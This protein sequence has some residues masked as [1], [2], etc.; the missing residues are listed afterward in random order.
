MLLA[1]DRIALAIDHARL[2]E[3]ERAAR[4]DAEA[5]NR[6]K[7]QFLATLSHELR[8]PLTSML[9]WLRM[10]RSGRLDA[11]MA[12]RALETLERSTRTQAQLINDLLDVSRIVSGKLTLDLG[13]VDADEV[14]A[15]A[16][17]AARPL[18]EAKSITVTHARAG[19]AAMVHGDAG[20]LEQVVW[21]LLSNAIKFTPDSGRVAVEVAVR[22]AEVRIA[23]TD[24]GKG[25][26]PELL[27]QIFER[28]R[29]AAPTRRQGGLGL[30]LAIVRHLAEIH[31]GRVAAASD[32]P[33][34]GARF[35]VYL[36]LADVMAVPRTDGGQDFPRL[37]G[38]RVLVVDDEPDARAL[39]GT[40]LE[41]C[42]ADVATVA[43]STAALEALRSAHFDVLLSDI[44]MPEEDGYQLIRK[45]RAMQPEIPAAAVTAFARAE[46]REAALAAGFQLHVAKPVEP[47]TL[48]RVVESLVRRAA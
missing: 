18:A 42:G 2:F 29:Q 44:S 8:T 4:A 9:G 37:S 34:R 27:P 32:G 5:A 25:I 20:R 41:Q 16:V 17:E 35:E 11:T 38:V 13:S 47:A 21:N 43:S 12:A 22:E 10:L 28:F 1:A 14:V 46:D 48:A 6:T 45:V 15:A 7:D 39:M 24:T 23:V 30:G 3:A 36:P 33:G 26:A 19:R 40:V 31:G